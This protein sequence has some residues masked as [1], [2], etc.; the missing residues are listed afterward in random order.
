MGK[1]QAGDTIKNDSG[2]SAIVLDTTEYVLLQWADGT[3]GTWDSKYFEKVERSYKPGDFVRVV[4]DDETNGV[5]GMV[6]DDDGDDENSDPFWVALFN[7]EGEEAPYS[8]HEL[9]PWHPAAGERVLEADV[10]DD[11]E[12]TIVFASNGNASVL[13]DGFP[14]P[15]DFAVADLEPVDECEDEDEDDFE[16]G[17]IVIYSHPMFSNTAQ[18]QVVGTLNDNNVIAVVFEPGTAVADGIYSKD[19]F[20]KAA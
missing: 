1:F 18:A 14:H 20:S 3:K 12:G 17:E 8:G 16:V 4:A 11:T 5:I 10:E 13:W 19:F 6:F 7:A 2:D 15:Q 9:E